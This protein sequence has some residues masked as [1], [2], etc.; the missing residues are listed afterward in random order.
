MCWSPPRRRPCIA[1]ACSA[2]A[3]AAWSDCCRM[4]AGRGR[5]L[6]HRG[7]LLGHR[8]GQLARLTREA[9]GR[10]GD[11]LGGDRLFGSPRAPSPA[12]PRRIE[13]TACEIS[14]ALFT[15]SPVALRDLDGE[16]RRVLRRLDDVARRAPLLG[17][18]LGGFLRDLAH[19]GGRLHDRARDG[20]LLARSRPRP[21]GPVPSWR[22]SAFTTVCAGARC[23]SVARAI[24][25][26]QCRGLG[27]AGTGSCVRPG[28][29]ALR[30]LR[31]CRRR[32]GAPRSRR[33]SRPARPPAAP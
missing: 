10:L 28:A 25:A 3:R 18:R 8:A 21:A 19:L 11:L 32:R 4:L 14:A 24:C 26:D 17:D 20:H 6:V 23:S 12:A 7:A 13:S 2:S 29:A 27:Q 33:S 1:R 30:Q 9:L 31:C 15:C 22:R 16:L 5:D